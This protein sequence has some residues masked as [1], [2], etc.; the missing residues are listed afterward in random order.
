MHPTEIIELMIVGFIIV[1]I[2]I[3]SLFLKGE[4]RKVGWSLALAVLVA[5]GLFYVVR[6]YWFDAQIDK[7]VELLKPYLEQHYPDESWEIS[8]VPHREEGFKSQNP[9]YI[10]V[11]FESEP[12][13]TYAY[14]VENENNISQSIYST[15]KKIDELEHVENKNE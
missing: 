3:I 9:Y 10:Q 11:V 1:A 12:D 13:V 8:I 14:W 6:P 4:W 7:K 2:V 5:Y 15:Y